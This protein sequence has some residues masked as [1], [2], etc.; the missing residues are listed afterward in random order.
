M[1]PLLLDM[2]KEE[3]V[4]NLRNLELEAYS[5]LVSALRAQGYP[6]ADKLKL[7]KD[8][9]YL[10]NISLD[11]H[12]AEVRRAISD[13]KLNTIAYHM[14]GHTASRE[15]WAKEGQRLVPLLTREAP[16]TLYSLVAND[17]SESAS[18]CNKLL[19]PPA[20]TERK[21][22]VVSPVTALATPET[23]KTIPF[24]KQ[25]ENVSKKRK[26]MVPENTNINQNVLGPKL[27]RIQQVYRQRTKLK[28]KEIVK[29]V[30][31]E[32]SELV[33]HRMIHPGSIHS[34][35]QS[36]TG[37]SSSSQSSQS[38]FVNQR[39]HILQNISL[40]S[41]KEELPDEELTDGN[42]SET[43]EH[44]IVP[45]VPLCSN[46]N[47]APK[48]KVITTVKPNASITVKQVS[49]QTAGPSTEPQKCIKITPKTP[50]TKT[51]NSGQKLIVVSNAQTIPSNSI[52]QR[53]LQIPFV[54][55]ISIKK[56]DKFKIVTSNST[57][58]NLHLTNVT[59]SGANSVKHKVVTVKTNPATKKVIPLSQ[60]QVMSSKGSIKV[61]PLGG[62]IVG[63]SMSGTSSPL[64][65]VN[66]TQVSK[67]TTTPTITT[68]KLQ[69]E[70]PDVKLE[71]SG[72]EIGSSASTTTT[73]CNRENGKSS[74]LEDI[75]KASGV[76]AEENA[77]EDYDS[78]IAEFHISQNKGGSE[79]ESDQLEEIDICE[80][81]VECTSI[82]DDKIQEDCISNDIEQNIKVEEKMEFDVN[83]IAEFEN[84]LSLTSHLSEEITTEEV[85]LDVLMDVEVSKISD[86]ECN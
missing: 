52:L 72:A 2:T 81:N 38:Q 68:S 27:C 7:L 16:Q 26:L 4:Q 79:N 65:I 33:Q 60:L 62:K 21:R 37:L 63:K 18:Q 41:V 35:S 20:S 5:Q 59:N 39:I 73:I 44:S 15:D 71:E 69:M 31:H 28:P 48:P 17:A 25:E 83:E 77:V 14:T 36:H 13:E 1:W 29:K 54:K 46:E 75:L 50:I 19:P 34:F 74:V 86:T 40:Q 9:G 55:N 58:T 49:P 3:S 12:K 10:L 32:H 85:P 76:I 22:P 64:Y 6:N 53:T 57:S 80:S 67:S 43:P 70:K 30:D 82:T 11:R 78:K 61:V 56:L 8:T 47:Q 45:Q 51:V 24:M 42:N 23:S 66:S 84:S